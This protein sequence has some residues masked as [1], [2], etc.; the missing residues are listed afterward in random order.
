MNNYWIA[1]DIL[2]LPPAFW[3]VLREHLSR[4]EM[5]RFNSLKN[6]KTDSGKVRAWFRSALN[7]HSLEKY[8]HSVINNGK[9][10]QFVSDSEFFDYF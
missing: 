1:I 4:H 5:E 7:E 9:V 3:I 8:L 10:L 6:I 2:Y